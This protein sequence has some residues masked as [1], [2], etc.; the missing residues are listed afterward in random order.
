MIRTLAYIAVALTLSV[1]ITN[2]IA[3]PAFLVTCEI[4]TSPYTGMSVFVG[5]YS[6]QGDEIVRT[7]PIGA[8]YCPQRIEVY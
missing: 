7:F 3:A 6:Y 1:M 2:A 5:T 8:G 4:Q